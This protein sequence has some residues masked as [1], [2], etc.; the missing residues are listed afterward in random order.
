[1]AKTSTLSTRFVHAQSAKTN[2]TAPALLV[3]APDVVESSI[4]LHELPPHVRVLRDGPGTMLERI[5][6]ALSTIWIETGQRTSLHLVGH[7][8]PGMMTVADLRLDA[9]ATGSDRSADTR[10]VSGL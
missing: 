7:G 10:A 8:T 2:S 1:M 9:A 5:R 4:L 6:G 3:I